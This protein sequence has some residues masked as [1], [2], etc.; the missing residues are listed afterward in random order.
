MFAVLALSTGSAAMAADSPSQDGIVPVVV[1]VKKLPDL[2][3]PHEINLRRHEKLEAETREIER[4]EFVVHRAMWAN[5]NILNYRFTVSTRGAWSGTEPVTV[6]VR[7]GK[8][9]STEYVCP[10]AECRQTDVPAADAGPFDTV[11]NIFEFIDGL[12]NHSMSLPRVHYDKRFGFP[13]N[14]LNDRIRISDDEFSVT[15]WDFQLLE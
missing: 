10:P 15:V 2:G 6:T 12:L 8:A 4:D 3:E 14:I 9:V 5:K 1:T 7:D 11:P 13:A